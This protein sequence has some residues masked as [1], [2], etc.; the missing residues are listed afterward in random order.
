MFF[1][2][3]SC[4]NISLPGSRAIEIDCAFHIKLS[5]NLNVF[6]PALRRFLDSLCKSLIL[7]GGTF[8][9]ISLVLITIP[10]FP[11]RLGVHQIYVRRTDIPSLYHNQQAVQVCPNPHTLG[12]GPFQNWS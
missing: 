12:P 10:R 1:S 8:S 5:R 4:R 2:S 7:E 11:Q 9:E 6:W 3:R